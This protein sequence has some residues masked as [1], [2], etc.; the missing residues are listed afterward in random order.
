VSP[1]VPPS[2]GAAP[3]DPHERL[4]GLRAWLA[5]VDRKLGLR[6]Y[7]LAAAALLALAAGVVGIVLALHV[8]NDAATN[9]DLAA[10]RTEVGAVKQSATQAAQR[11]VQS[12]SARVDQLASD[13]QRLDTERQT[14]DRE[15]QVLQ[16]DVRDL[17]NQVSTLESQGSSTS[18]TR[19]H[20]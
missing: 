6:T 18:G 19:T 2:A 14:T 3:L 15:I 9:D 11:T 13:V 16:G 8:Q 4:D 5:Q 17:Q 10:L 7:L 20:P 12:L 1:P